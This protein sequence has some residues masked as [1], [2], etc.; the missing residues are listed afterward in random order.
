MNGLRI[1]K[2]IMAASI[3][4]KTKVVG[5]RTVKVLCSAFSSTTVISFSKEESLKHLIGSTVQ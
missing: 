4:S 5:E 3:A 1:I 2:P